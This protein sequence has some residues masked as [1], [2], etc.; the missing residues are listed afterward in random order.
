MP[1]LEVHLVE[2]LHSPAQLEELL[3]RASARTAEVLDTPIEG[4]RAFVTLHRP[5]TWATAG[6]T[7]GESAPY[8]VAS[9]LAGRAVEARHRLLAAFADIA[10]DVLRVDR[11]LVRSRIVT[12][13]PEDF[14]RGGV[15]ASAAR[16][17]EATAR[18]I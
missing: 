6:R 12:V 17:G 3:K 14:A 10:V 5:E 1:I 18:P 7:G 16:R 11:R 15:P 4:V 2:G 13:E 8:L 9:L